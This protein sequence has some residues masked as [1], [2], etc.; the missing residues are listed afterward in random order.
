MTC[1]N[2]RRFIGYTHEDA[3]MDFSEHDKQYAKQI[4][5]RLL[6]RHEERLDMELDENLVISDLE[7]NA[8][9]FSSELDLAEEFDLSIPAIRI[10]G[11][12]GYVV[13]V[14]LFSILELP[15]SKGS[16]SQIDSRRRRWWRINP[17]L[18]D[19]IVYLRSIKNQRQ[20]AR[21][22]KISPDEA[23]RAFESHAIDFL[24]MRIAAVGN[25][26]EGNPKERESWG[27]TAQLNLLQKI[28]GRRVTTPG[29][30]FSVSTNSN[31]LRVFWSGAYY[32][33]PNYFSHPTSP[34]TSILQSGTYIF[35]VDGGVYRNTIQWDT[36]AVTTLPG[37]SLIH[38]NY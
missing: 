12:N 27:K 1:F 32:I 9:S 5:G 8:D 14:S 28:G 33:S 10:A 38:L 29:C 3:R 31:G 6:S 11:D 4:V 34:V 16:N 37:S 36:N 17:N 2:A 15:Y 21:F 35:G 30:Y 19:M 13:P 18:R 26:S 25:Y 20:L 23:R 24:A 7:S 22:Q